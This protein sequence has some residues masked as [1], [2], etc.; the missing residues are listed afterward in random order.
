MEPRED[1]E[2]LIQEKFQESL[3]QGGSPAEAY[4]GVGHW[5]MIEEES[6]KAILAFEKSI[7]ADPRYTLSHHFLG[8]VY[9]DMGE[10]EKAIQ[11]FQKCIALGCRGI[12]PKIQEENSYY[13]MGWCYEDLGRL[14]EAKAAFRQGITHVPRH[15]EGYRRLGR[16]LQKQEAYAEAATVYQQALE[17]CA[18]HEPGLLDRILLKNIQYN[19]DRAR[20]RQPYAEYQPTP[21]DRTIDD[22]IRAE[23]LRRSDEQLRRVISERQRPSPERTEA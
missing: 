20:N 13:H 11:Y 6:D 8:I 14:E 15:Y 18:Q 4:F 23:K 22:R 1:L 21:E 12:D 19:F 5:A 10:N 2:G 16:L 17:I 9:A 7:A 3:S